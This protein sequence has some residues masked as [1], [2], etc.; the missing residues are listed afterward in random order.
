M[1]VRPQQLGLA[2]VVSVMDW[3][4]LHIED[5]QLLLR[6]SL[7]TMAAG[8]FAS[9]P[10]IVDFYL[11]RPTYLPDEMS[12]LDDTDFLWVVPL[13][14]TEAAFARACGWR[15]LE[16]ELVASDPDLLDLT[17]SIGS[18]FRAN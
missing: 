5:G 16:T 8:P 9:A 13:L 14:P 6:G 18:G 15:A 7:H 17:R 3:M 2:E 1:M 10:D 4:G 11:T 12:S